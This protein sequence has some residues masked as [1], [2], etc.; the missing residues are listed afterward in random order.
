MAKDGMRDN[1]H[2]VIHGTILNKVSVEQYPLDGLDDVIIINLDSTRKDKKMTNTESDYPYPTS[3][4]TNWTCPK[5]FADVEGI[6]YHVCEHV[7]PPK[8]Y[9]EPYRQPI[10]APQEIKDIVKLLTQISSDLKA[11]RW[12]R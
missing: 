7:E 5:C 2:L 1:A 3:I 9:Q 4:G 11:M 12:N 10:P 8:P 6:A